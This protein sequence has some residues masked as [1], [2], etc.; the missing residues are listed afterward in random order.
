VLLF[1]AD[2]V[3]RKVELDADQRAALP[4]L[5]DAYDDELVWGPAKAVG[6]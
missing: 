6:R 5:E 3:P 1:R 2:W 4:E